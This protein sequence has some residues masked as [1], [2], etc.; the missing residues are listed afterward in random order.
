[1]IIKLIEQDYQP[2]G[3]PITLHIPK[4]EFA[5]SAVDIVT[6]IR[7]FIAQHVIPHIPFTHKDD[8]ARKA[9]LAL[10]N[11]EFA[12]ELVQ[13]L[14]AH[15]KPDAAKALPFYFHDEERIIETFAQLGFLRV[16]LYS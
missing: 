8:D 9:L 2:E 4:Q 16:V 13:Y 5:G 6:A 10:S 3:S 14:A 15:G 7:I 11:N 1:M 12:T